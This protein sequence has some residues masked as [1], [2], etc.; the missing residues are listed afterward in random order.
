MNEQD[1]A[2]LIKAAN[3]LDEEMIP[4][5]MERGMPVDARNKTGWTPLMCVANK[6]HLELVRYFVDRGADI[7]A[8]N[9]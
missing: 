2:P 8:R 3:A 1:C 4:S 9:V 6:G 5:L 7:N